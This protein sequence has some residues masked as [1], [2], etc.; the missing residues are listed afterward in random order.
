MVGIIFIVSYSVVAVGLLLF[1][2]RKSLQCEASLKERVRLW[3]VFGFLFNLFSFSWLYTAYPLIWLKEGVLQLVGIGLLHLIVATISGCCFFVVAYVFEKKVSSRIHNHIKPAIFALTLT[4]AEILRALAISA[5]YY[6][7]GSTLDLNFAGSMLGHALAATPFVEYAYYGG[8]FMLTFV[9]GYMVYILSSQATIQK[10]WPHISVLCLLLVYVHY[11][12]PTFGPH[13]PMRVS[14][15]TTNFPSIQKDQDITLVFREQSTKIHQM[16]M[17]L[18][19]SSPSIIVYPEDSR[20]I[21]NLSEKNKKELNTFFS[22]T[23]FID[24][25][26]ISHN[27]KLVNSSLFYLTQGEKEIRRGKS[28]LFPFNEYIPY[29]FVPVVRLFVPQEQ[30]NEYLAGHTYT[31]IQ[32]VKTIPF[33]TDN[34]STLICY[35]ITSFRVLDDIKKENPSLVF[36][37]SHL[38]VFHDNPWFTMHLY[39]YAK[40]A[41]SQLRRPL[42]SSVNGSPSYIISPFGNILKTIPTGFS[43]STYT[44]YKK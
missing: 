43:T 34:M 3:I 41:A 30:M 32:S 19:S 7:E 13:T 37:Q 28:I 4:L 16:T 6:G 8:P 38:N 44:F 21:G 27:N 24:G 23:L 2:I 10:Y 42:I 12:V 11:E 20:Y 9:L 5:L 18:S 22:K 15:V 36:F 25:D 26:T 14:I 17:S 31:P 35:E 40:T 1:F 29:V 33:G 39:L